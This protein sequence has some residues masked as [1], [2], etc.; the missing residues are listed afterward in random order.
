[1]SR[2]TDVSRE[3]STPW[4]T[5]ISHERAAREMYLA[6][7]ARAHHEYLA[8]PWPD[9]DAYLIVER[10]AYTTYYQAGREAW[11]FYRATMET[12]PPP[13]A[14]A[15]GYAPNFPPAYAGNDNTS[16]PPPP[17]ESHPYPEIKYEMPSP[18]PRHGQATFTP[19]PDEAGP[20]YGEAELR[21]ADGY[22][23]HPETEN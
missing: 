12:P 19:Y 5:Y 23:D 3:T 7:T 10:D 17:A 4:Q 21:R 8:G 11:R 18:P 14:R 6:V 20:A 9:R 15:V 16:P 22:R 13:P 2:L 1:V